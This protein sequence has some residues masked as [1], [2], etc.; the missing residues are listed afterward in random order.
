M[1]K[2]KWLLALLVTVFV[3]SVF[4]RTS[5]IFDFIGKAVGVDLFL[6][7]MTRMSWIFAMVVLCV[8]VVAYLLKS[9]KY[10]NGYDFR[11]FFRANKV[12]I[13]LTLGIILSAILSF[14]FA[15]DK[16]QPL[17][18]VFY[19]MLMVLEFW[20]VVLLWGRIITK[21]WKKINYSIVIV[22]LV[23]AL[24]QVVAYANGGLENPIIRFFDSFGGHIPVSYFTLGIEST[25]ILRPSSL[26]AD[27]NFVG[28]FVSLVLFFAGDEVLVGIKSR[29]ISWFAV[30][31]FVSSLALVFLTNSRTAF[32]MVVVGAMAY[33]FGL[34]MN[35]LIDARQVRKNAS[36]INSKSGEQKAKRLTPKSTLVIVWIDSLFK[37]VSDALTFSDGSSQEHL[38]F[39]R[40]AIVIFE[41]YPLFGVGI[42]N[43]PL[44]Y[45]ILIDS[46]LVFATPH[47]AYLKALS[48]LGL[49]GFTVLMAFVVYFAVLILR[50]RKPVLMAI[51]SAILVG[52][53]F[54]DFFMTP[55]VLFYLAV[56][57][58]IISRYDDRK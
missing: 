9:R 29:K 16:D 25:V 47:S 18:G 44:Y 42:G 4:V 55:W 46:T 37:R 5:I 22:L 34:I 50:S 24:V 33:I 31:G 1:S 17:Y 45:Q 12:V 19:Y 21:S 40:G 13:S 11:G 43:Y 38:R 41:A 30:L 36:E 15:P 8:A 2:S 27:P 35:R 10:S 48:E 49:V 32:V 53:L 57:Y 7:L 14:I 54:Y 26:M 58:C 52:N 3:A 39:A 56:I 28:I 23:V 20:L 51:F 6:R